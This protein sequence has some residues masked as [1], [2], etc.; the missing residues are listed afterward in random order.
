MPGNVA[1]FR[2]PDAKAAGRQQ[3]RDPLT[4][5]EIRLITDFGQGLIAEGR[6]S[7][8]RRVAGR[9]GAEVV[10]LLDPNGII[11]FGI[12]KAATGYKCFNCDGETIDEDESLVALLERRF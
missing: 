5:T 3:T 9:S 10:V 11:E 12:E 6:V 2:L 1:E 7:A 4:E 8:V